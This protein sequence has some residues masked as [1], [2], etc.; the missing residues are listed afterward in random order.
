MNLYTILR[1]LVQG[2]KNA[3]QE[4]KDYSDARGDYIVEEGTSGIWTYRKWAS[5]I[6]ECWG[7]YSYN[8]AISST[9][10]NAY[11]GSK[12]GHQSYPFTFIERPFEIGLLFSK[13]NVGHWTEQFET[14]SASE[15]G[16]YHPVRPNSMSASSA[17]ELHLYVKGFWKS[18][19][20]VGGVIL[21]LL[22]NRRVVFA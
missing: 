12:A 2:I 22:N 14:N 20:N 15:S 18:F 6:A 5:G 19:A 1:N 10:G 13:G 7:I 21:N 3:L 11:E 17:F 8:T 4:A 9:W 16:T